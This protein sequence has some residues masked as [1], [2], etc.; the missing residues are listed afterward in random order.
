MRACLV[1]LALCAHLPNCVSEPSRDS[2]GANKFPLEKMRRVMRQYTIPV[3]Y[4]Y[5][6]LHLLLVGRWNT[7]KYIVPPSP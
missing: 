7:A 5:I 3:A 2:D 4:N 1:E 6:I